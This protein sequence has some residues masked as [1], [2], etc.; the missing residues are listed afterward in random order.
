MNVTFVAL[1]S[2]NF[3]AS[4]IKDLRPIGLIG[5]VYKILAKVLINRLKDALGKLL[6]QSKN[7]FI[8]GS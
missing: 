2:K 1:I 7:T 8:K 6:S 5:S 4:D 3:R